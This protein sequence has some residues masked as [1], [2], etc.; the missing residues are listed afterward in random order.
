MLRHG[1]Q[2]KNLRCG[3]LSSTVFGTG[4]YCP[5][6]NDGI[7]DT[8][9]QFYMNAEGLNPGLHPCVTSALST[10]PSLKPWWHFPIFFFLLF[11]IAILKS[12][13]EN[14][15]ASTAGNSICWLSVIDECKR[16][17]DVDEWLRKEPWAFSH[18]WTLDDTENFWFD[19]HFLIFL[20]WV[21]MAYYCW[22]GARPLASIPEVPWASLLFITLLISSYPLGERS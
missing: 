1:H 17:L 21:T 18:C 5:C 13:L 19:W 6:G 4:F 22:R 7:T 20:H 12:L 9:A 16:F 10:D 14:S 15:D 3:S 11:I 8:C 2:K